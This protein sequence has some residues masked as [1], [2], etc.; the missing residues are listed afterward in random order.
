MNVVSLKRLL[1]LSLIP[2]IWVTGF[3]WSAHQSAPA[4]PIMI[5]VFLDLSGPTSDFGRPTLNGV[6]MAAAE[7][8]EAGGIGGRP[9]E[10]IVEDDLGRSYQAA[11][12][13]ESLIHQKKVNAILGGVTS[14]N[15]LAAAPIAQ[16]AKVS[17]I[18]PFATHPAVTAVGN[19]IFRASFSDSFQGEALAEFA[20]RKLNVKRAAVLVDTNSDYSR[21]LATAFEQNLNRLGVQVVSSQRYAAGDRDFMAQLV[22]IKSRRADF[23]FVSGYYSEAG[24]IARQA[25]QIRLNI[26]LLGGDGWDSPQL[27]G[28]GGTSLNGSYIVHHYA[29]DNPSPTNKE[30]VGRYRARYENREP[31]AFAAL[32]YD[33]MKLLADAMR[34]AATNGS[35]LQEALTRTRN[36]DGV[37]GSI[38]IDRD[39][40]TIKPAVIL[41]LQD[42][43]FG[44][45]ATIYPG[46]AKA[47]D[48]VS[49]EATPNKHLQLT[50]R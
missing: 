10:L 14:S 41:K 16:H 17:M 33:A 12:V 27:W 44:Y 18:T 25:R 9:L 21:T 46:K 29:S 11:S 31:D 38:T 1:V 49:G 7:M 4:E 47:K 20:A 39:R 34:R 3:G 22:A 30:F 15:S 32:G 28:L 48:S 5:G 35:T 13:V 6:K 40:D 45:H 36:F 8:N 2:V 42:G 23:I 43:K 26:P 24:I 50:A 37:T 19:Y